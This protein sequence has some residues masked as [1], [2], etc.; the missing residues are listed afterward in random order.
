VPPSKSEGM[1]A[2]KGD[3]FI[4]NKQGE[5]SGIPGRIISK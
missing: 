2:K 1:A 3:I 4:L 5:I